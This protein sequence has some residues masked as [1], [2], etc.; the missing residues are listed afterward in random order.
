MTRQPLSDDYIAKA[1][2]DA[3]Q[4]QGTWDQGTG[5]TLA[6]HTVR[7]IRER[8]M[9]LSNIAELEAQ[10][11][12]LLEQLDALRGGCAEQEL[13]SDVPA[14]YL[15]ENEKFSF[16][17]AKPEKPAVFEARMAASSMPTEALEAAWAGVHQRHQ[18]MMRR[19]AGQPI[20]SVEIPLTPK[21]TSP[22]LIGISGRAGSGKNAA[23]SMIPGAVVVQLA[24]PLYAGLSAM[25]GIPE[26]LMRN[27]DYKERP[28]P[29]IGKSV[30]QLLQ[31]LGTEWGRSTVC[32]D[33]WI[34]L[35]ERRVEHLRLAG[36]S[37]V[38]V[39]DVRFQNEAEWIRSSG[40]K[41]WHVRREACRRQDDHASEA[42]IPF[43]VRDRDI[44]NDGT[45]DDLR[46]SVLAAF[47]P[48]A[49]AA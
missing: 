22:L 46:R 14:E 34:R 17:P 18:E 31:T 1:M 44:A 42:G 23:A 25:L 38:A 45:L 13:P 30:R 26:T 12:A 40:G 35:L 33:V 4:F 37:V 6:A 15:R 49:A 10:C 3:R 43:D 29:G 9:H 21:A 8:E 39:A 27:R 20:E 28:V 2:Q 7:L 19:A 32:G 36:V 16:R 41:V 5:G 11:R 48:Q 24:D 47:S